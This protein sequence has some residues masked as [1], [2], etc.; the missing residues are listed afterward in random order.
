VKGLGIIVGV[1]LAALCLLVW[2]DPAEATTQCH[3]SNN[4]CEGFAHTSAGAVAAARCGSL[5]LTNTAPAC[6]T[7]GVTASNEAG[8]ELNPGECTTFYYFLGSTGVSPPPVPN[9]VVISAALESGG[10]AVR[11]YKDGTTTGG[12]PDASGTS[13]QFCATNDGTST[14]SPRSGTV[15]WYLR[16]I[17]DDAAGGIGN[18]NVDSTGIAAVGTNV[19]FDQGV[20]R[21]RTYV[22]ALTNNAHAS[23]AAYGTAG[24]ETVTITATFTPPFGD[25]NRETIRTG[26]IDEGT[27]AIG[28]AGT[29][30]DYDGTS[31]FAQGYV[32]DQTFPS[33]S[34]P[35]VGALEIVGNNIFGI[36]WTEM[37]V[38]G[39]CAT[40]TVLS[41]LVVYNSADFVINPDVS[42]D[43]DGSGTP[44]NLATVKL[45]NC[46]GPV[47]TLE[48]RGET[49]CAAWYLLNSR[50]EQLT[51]SMTFA[52][53]DASAVVCTNHGS[54]SPT[55][56]LYTV[57][58]AIPTAG[59]CT[60]ANTITG[61]ARHMRATN[62]DQSE[63]SADFL[64]VS[65]LYP[66]TAHTQEPGAIGTEQTTFMVRSN[67]AG[68]DASDTIAVYCHVSGVRGDVDIDTSGSAVTRS[69]IDP[70]PTTR[71]T[72]T[73]DTGADGWTPAL[74]LLATT[75][76]GTAWTAPCSVAFNGNTGSD[77][78]IFEVGV[79][80]GGEGET[81]YTGADP[82]TIFGGNVANGT[83]PITVHS[84]LLDGE[85]RVG[86]A[87]QIFVSVYEWP[88]MAAVVTGGAVVE[89]DA[90]NAPG[91]YVYNLTF[92]GPG[93]YLIAANTT[94]GA[95]PIGAHNVIVLANS[96]VADILA[97]LNGHRNDTLEILGM[98]FAG[99]T[100][101][102]LLLSAIWLGVLVWALRNKPRPYLMVAAAATIGVLLLF[103]PIPAMTHVFLVFLVAI[104]VWLESIV[105]DRVYE[106]LTGDKTTTTGP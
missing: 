77:T 79:E 34:S 64:Y 36:K 66:T 78:Q 4:W 69:L 74:T 82:L 13:Y 29:T 49:G 94:D 46:S 41:D 65:S 52:T 33:A 38:A 73:T 50:G 58:W 22:S 57:T 2:A 9:K 105:G 62:T 28:A 103:L 27:L 48:N 42:F 20:M 76:L 35:Y 88:T 10:T 101:A 72:G 15:R 39:H 102:E 92:P 98:D 18:Y 56:G 55:A 44:D 7:T 11:V 6:T 23:G 53:E 87:D 106:R 37:A 61:S 63:L 16:I 32:I 54:L 71:A 67:G 91:S 25:V 24:D 93:A 81:V 59:S 99:L 5:R 97:S 12:V 30:V 70:T 104:A 90:V 14:G 40:C 89:V 95:T 84:R 31:P 51:R 96:T 1:G 47:I 17:K 21:A 75:P 86:V 19:G 100:F 26:I 45:T 3:A 60:V 85:A 80:G 83:V 43:Q 68:G 8:W